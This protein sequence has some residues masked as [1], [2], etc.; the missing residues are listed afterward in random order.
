MAADTQQ[1]R[2]NGSTCRYRY[3]PSSQSFGPCSNFSTN[4][5]QSGRRGG[6]K[7]YRGRGR[8]NGSRRPPLDS[9]NQALNTYQGYPGSDYS[10]NH[11]PNFSNSFPANCWVNRVCLWVT[12][13]VSHG[14]LFGQ[15]VADHGLTGQ[16]LRVHADV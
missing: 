8:S 13:V 4:R 9:F 15:R 16:L 6:S 10:P 11:H 5:Y 14:I 1:R 12:R 3:T 2:S 7:F